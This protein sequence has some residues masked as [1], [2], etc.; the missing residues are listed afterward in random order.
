M[1]LGMRKLLVLGLIGGILLTAS[2]PTA[3]AWLT[4]TGL[5]EAASRIQDTFLTGTAVTIT[6]VL[7]ILL[8]TLL[9][10]IAVYCSYTA[11]TE[12]EKEY[13]VFLLLLQVMGIN[14][15]ALAVFGGALGVGIGFGLQR[16]A[17]NFVSG[18]ILL[19]ER[20]IEIGDIVQIDNNTGAVQKIGIRSTNIKTRD[21]VELII[22]NSY[23]L[24]QIVTNLTRSEDLAKTALHRLWVEDTL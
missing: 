17:S 13:Y 4:R 7:L 15:T 3:A 21:N 14:L 24:T 18:F 5:V 12:R 23:F 6:V 22:P 11:I 16:I 19:F 20:S 8:T 2:A 9:G 10:F 1:T